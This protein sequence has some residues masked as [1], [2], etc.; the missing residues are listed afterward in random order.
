MNDRRKRVSSRTGKALDLEE[1]GPGSDVLVDHRAQAPGR[2]AV[3]LNEQ[4][5]LAVV[6]RE[7]QLE[8]AG[9][10]HRLGD[11]PAVRARLD[12]VNLNSP[13]GDCLRSSRGSERDDRPRFGACHDRRRQH[14]GC[15]RGRVWRACREQDPI[16]EPHRTQWRRRAGHACMV[17]PALRHLPGQSNRPGEKHGRS[18]SMAASSRTILLL[19]R[20]ATCW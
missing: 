9:I 18:P 2:L 7:P 17:T 1:V 13:S 6:Q 15:A 20:T 3:A 5:A 19:T 10:G 16:F 4:V 11:Q 12:R 14:H 8:R